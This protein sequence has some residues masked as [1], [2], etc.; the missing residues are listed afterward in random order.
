MRDTKQIIFL[1]YLLI[2]SQTSTL[3]SQESLP[4]YS[5]Y[6]TDNIYLVHPAGA[7]INN[8]GKIRLTGRKQWL[9]TK[10]TP[11]LQTLSFH[12]HFG[13]ESALGIILFNDSNGHFS[14]SGAYLTYAYHISF[15]NFTI[16]QFSFGLSVSAIRN[17][18]NGTD[19]DLP[20]PEVQP[21]ILSKTFINSDFGFAY[22]NEGFFTFYTLKNAFLSSKGLFDNQIANNKPMQ[23]L[24]TLGYFFNHDKENQIKIQ[25]SVMFQ[26][27]TKTKEVVVDSNLKVFYP[28]LDDN[29]VWTGMSFRK[30]LEIN[31]LENPNYFT[32]FLGVD[33]NSFVISYSYTKQFNNSIYEKGDFHQISLGYNFYIE[34]THVNQPTWSL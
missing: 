15:D 10:G 3:F 25:P 30:G 14:N 11:E 26:Y 23:H 17:T 1:F 9:G 27:K 21:E 12:T 6:L 4:I 34:R 5:D 16:N 28:L 31:A 7:G 13:E 32:G 24:F 19:F 2:I 18:L 22:K 8:Y 33:Y 29:R 20:D